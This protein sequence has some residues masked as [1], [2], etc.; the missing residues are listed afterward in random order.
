MYVRINVCMYKCMCV[1]TD[2]GISIFVTFSAIVG[3][4]VTSLLKRGGGRS[5]QRSPPNSSHWQISNMHW[6]RFE[7]WQWW[8]NASSQWQLSRPLG[9]QG[10]PHMCICIHASSNLCMYVCVCMYVCMYDMYVCV[11]AFTICM[12]MCTVVIGMCQNIHISV[13]DFDQ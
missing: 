8:E 5:T 12:Y 7:P 4:I 1:C 3:Y 9:Q 2:F 11:Y 10:S 6:L 13:F